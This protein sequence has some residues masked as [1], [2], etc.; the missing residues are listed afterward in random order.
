MKKRSKTQ[1][2]KKDDK[3]ILD[4]YSNI[5]EDISSLS[6]FKDE[7]IIIN[8]L[9]SK[10]ITD[11]NKANYFDNFFQ[12]QRVNK[13]EIQIDGKV[14]TSL[15]SF[16]EIKPLSNFKPNLPS[17]ISN[18]TLFE[19][20]KS[21]EIK[22]QEP[23]VVLNTKSN[24]IEFENI[25][26]ATPIK[27]TNKVLNIKNFN[28]LLSGSIGLGTGLAMMPVFNK[29]LTSIDKFGINI[30]ANKTAFI[31]STINTL[32]VTTPAITLPTYKEL[33]NKTIYD[34]S[35]KQKL[36]FKVALGLSAIPPLLQVSQ[37]WN[38][39][40]HDQEVAKSSG[41]DEYIAWAT[42]TTIPLLAGQIIKNLNNVRD[43]TYGLKP[44]HELDSLGSKVFVYSTSFLSTLGRAI[45]YTHA[46]KTFFDNLGCDENFSLSLGI[47]LGGLLGS[48]INGIIE[49][50]N[51]KSLFSKS[52]DN[53]SKKEI[54]LGV[55]CGIEG[56][57]FSLPTISDG[58]EMTENWNEF[59][60]ALIFFPTFISRAIH[61]STLLYNSLQPDKDNV[62]IIDSNIQPLDS[63]I[64]LSG[65]N[66]ISEE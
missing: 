21:E 36:L 46:I 65:D 2:N 6:N 47:I 31:T 66:L 23:N 1:V 39:E 33:S 8:R 35:Q 37:L 38:T 40:L 45:A 57:W 62:L 64:F 13:K 22:E 5:A 32:A 30:H 60:Q 41:F 55:L 44:N 16:P 34:I 3:I 53:L 24:E 59:L 11:S 56:A 20:S 26:P 9:I 52:T 14:G 27:N 48:S 18:N 61:E 54:A 51:I 58:L 25:E 43:F 19:E 49:F 50:N 10:D 28:H 42:C 17:S 4:H 15:T 7:D 63:N 12:K 29:E